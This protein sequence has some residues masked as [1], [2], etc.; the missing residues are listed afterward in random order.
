LNIAKC[1]DNKE[2]AR[3]DKSEARKKNKVKLKKI[4]SGPLEINFRETLIN[5]P[6]ESSFL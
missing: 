2:L 1:P 3:R 5:K 6:S 4:K